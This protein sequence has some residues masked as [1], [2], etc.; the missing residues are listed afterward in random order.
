MRPPTFR[1]DLADAG[2]DEQQPLALFVLLAPHLL[3]RGFDLR[4][5]LV[6]AALRL[7]RPA[8]LWR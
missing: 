7:H 2:L 5:D 3:L 8:Q 4:L 6:H 1:L